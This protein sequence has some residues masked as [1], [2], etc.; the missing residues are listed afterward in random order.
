MRYIY[1]DFTKCTGYLLSPGIGLRLNSRLSKAR[2]G[3]DNASVSIAESPD[4]GTEAAHRQQLQPH[5]RWCG[6]RYSLRSGTSKEEQLQ[7]EAEGSS[8]LG[9]AQSVHLGFCDLAEVMP[10]V[11]NMVPGL[12]A[13]IELQE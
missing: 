1:L 6:R 12:P 8:L 2:I 9:V 10:V 5:R 3:C 7:R 11:K 13:R 4:T